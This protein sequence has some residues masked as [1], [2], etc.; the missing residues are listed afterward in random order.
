M[1]RWFLEFL[2]LSLNER[3]N[4]PCP[5]VPGIDEHFF[6]RRHGYATT[7][8]DLR[9]HR[10]HDVVL[11]RSEAPLEKY[12]NRLEGKHLVRVVCMDLASVYARWSAG[13]SPMPASWPTAFT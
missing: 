11:G 12:L 3:S 13:R 6:S 2:Q 9:A 5:P 7:F 10:I 4:A 1:E 8:C